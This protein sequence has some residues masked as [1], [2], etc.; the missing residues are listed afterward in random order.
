MIRKFYFNTG[1]KPHMNKG[2]AGGAIRGG[3]WQIPF[4]CEDVPEGACFKCACDSKEL[5]HSG[6]M[7]I[8]EILNSEGMVSKYAYFT[9]PMNIKTNKGE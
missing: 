9:P 2:V 8:R 3:V 7:I 5:P 1:V 4:E 6:N